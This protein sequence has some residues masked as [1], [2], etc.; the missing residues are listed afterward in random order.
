M[1]ELLGQM[2]ALCFAYD[3]AAIIGR[4]DTVSEKS[5]WERHQQADAVCSNL[6]VPDTLQR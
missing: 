5:L 6:A 3:N 1:R 2:A 4:M